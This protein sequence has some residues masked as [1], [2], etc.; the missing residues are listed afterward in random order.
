MKKNRLISLVLIVLFTVVL[1]ITNKYYVKSDMFSI[2]GNTSDM[3]IESSNDISSFKLSIETQKNASNIHVVDSK[4]ISELYSILE[5]I[6]LTLYSTSNS[7]YYDSEPKSSFVV[8]VY[9]EEDSKRQKINFLNSRYIMIDNKVYR[10]H[11]GYDSQEL[12]YYIN[13]LIK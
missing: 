10:V 9:S 2:I 6:E 1:I 5:S 3:E 12:Y 7:L 8:L 13:E 11:D 4:R